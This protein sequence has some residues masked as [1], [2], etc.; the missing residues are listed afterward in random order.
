MQAS[1]STHYVWMLH[2][3][4]QHGFDQ[5][6][7]AALVAALAAVRGPQRSPD[8]HNLLGGQAL[9]GST[10]S[11]QRKQHSMRA[12]ARRLVLQS[13]LQACRDLCQNMPS[14]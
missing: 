13:L 11:P 14:P 12:P 10:T 5:R 6:H 9:K 8:V 7:A 3:A 4:R 1:G 2:G